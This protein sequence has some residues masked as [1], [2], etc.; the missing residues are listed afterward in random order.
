[1]EIKGERVVLIPIKPADKEEFYKLATQTEGAKFWYGEKG[2]AKITRKKFF[3]DWQD[4]YFNESLPDKGQSFWIV[5]DGEKI[6]QINYN[7]ID[8]DKKE[9]ELDIII[10]ESQNMGRG[11]GTDALKTLIRHLFDNFDID[12]IWV[13]TRVNNQRAVAVCEKAGLKKE[14]LLEKEDM[15]EGELVDKIVLGI[16]RKN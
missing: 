5:A 9:A 13:K 14:A 2:R 4:D 16:L 6:G 1:M 15:F 8:L 7:A 12:K 3:D 11:Y 10:G